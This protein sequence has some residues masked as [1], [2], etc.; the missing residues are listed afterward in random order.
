VAVLTLALGTGA[1]TAVFSLVDGIL[2]SRLPY[3]SP[4]R[5]V[6]IKA[7]YPN[8]AFAALRKE[9]TSLDVAAYADGKWFT[10]TGTG[11]PGRVSGARISANL[12]QLLVVK[13]EAPWH[14]PH[15]PRHLRRGRHRH[16][17]RHAGGVL[18]P[19]R[20]AMGVNPLVVLRD[21]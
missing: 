18:C 12:F 16:H 13:P 5:L 1:N 20:R 2:L 3:P 11:E 8:G 17:A 7:T 10:L 15:R 21:Q 9:I 19:T 14:Q 6:S 4:D